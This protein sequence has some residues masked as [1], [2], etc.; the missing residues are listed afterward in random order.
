MEK[1]LKGLL[2]LPNFKQKMKDFDICPKM[3]RN[4][5]HLDKIIVATGFEKLP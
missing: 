4:I 5:D 1:R 3:P 2:K